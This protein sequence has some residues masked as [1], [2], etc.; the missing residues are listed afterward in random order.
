MRR[1][2]SLGAFP[3]S[4]CRRSGTDVPELLLIANTRV[5]G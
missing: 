4:V 2:L 1:V 3:G 5:R